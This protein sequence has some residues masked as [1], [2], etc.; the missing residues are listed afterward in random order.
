MRFLRVSLSPRRLLP[1]DV[2][3]FPAEA[4]EPVAF[5]LLA[6]A[7]LLGL[8]NAMPAVTGAR[9]AVSGGAVVPA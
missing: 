3:G 8:P 7:R 9:R 5:A 6:R 1:A 2:L 4:I